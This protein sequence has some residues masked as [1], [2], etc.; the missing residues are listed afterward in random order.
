MFKKNFEKWH[1]KYKKKYGMIIVDPD[2]WDRACPDSLEEKITWKEFQKRALRSSQVPIGW[3]G[4][5]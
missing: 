4:R 3:D 5:E 2:G 1:K